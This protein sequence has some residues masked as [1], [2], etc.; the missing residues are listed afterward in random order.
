MARQTG[1]RNV[2]KGVSLREGRG[3]QLLRNIEGKIDA[4]NKVG[5]R[6][7]NLVKVEEGDKNNK[8]SDV[9]EVTLGGAKRLRPKRGAVGL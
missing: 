6:E 2:K 4:G 8:K 7:S 9:D 1:G 3:K 5:T